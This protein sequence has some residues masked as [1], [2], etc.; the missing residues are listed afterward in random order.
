MARLGFG[1][2]IGGTGIKGA[3][4]DLDRGALESDRLR[5]PTPQPATVEGV[6]QV[7]QQVV[8]DGG[9]DGPVGCTFPGIVRHG[10][11][12]S[13]ANVDQGWI[14]T[15][16]SAALSDRLG[17]PV[18]VLN[19]AD[20]AGV[21]EMRFGAGR[22][23]QAGVVLIVTLGTGIGSALFTDGVLVPNT[24]LGH[25]E[26]DGAVAEH[27]AANSARLRDDLDFTE[28]SQRLQVYLSHI[29]RLF[30]PDLF[31]VGGGVSKKAHK[32]LPRLELTAPIVPAHLRNES[33]IV[34]AAAHAEEGVPR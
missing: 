29:E 27:R 9:W 20:A 12:G 13:A 3:V 2:D 11:V 24:E 7:V 25:L 18:G 19:D 5:R 15:D 30:S 33:G 31:I 32:F 4:V 16:L 10:V 8:E 17:R 28:W 6:L 34:G 22:E 26:L 23:H 1:I 21:A 14:G